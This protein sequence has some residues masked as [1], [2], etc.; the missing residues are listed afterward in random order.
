[1]PTHLHAVHS[2][3]LSCPA[4][5]CWIRLERAW[6]QENFDRAMRLRWAAPL[7]LLAVCLAGGA[8]ALF[9]TNEVETLTSA[10][11]NSKLKKG[12]W[13]VAFYAPVRIPD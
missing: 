2:T 1:M 7:L 13:A 6:T 5:C 9:E 3:D 11:F 12:A 4:N 8:W 10:N